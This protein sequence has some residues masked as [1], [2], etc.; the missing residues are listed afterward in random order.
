M[1][2]TINIHS[3]NSNVPGSCW[4]VSQFKFVLMSAFL[5]QFT[6]FVETQFGVGFKNKV[7]FTKAKFAKPSAAF[8][9]GWPFNYFPFDCMF[10]VLILQFPNIFRKAGFAWLSALFYRL[11][12]VGEAFF[13]S[14]FGCPN[15]ELLSLVGGDSCLVDDCRLEAVSWQGAFIRH[16]AIA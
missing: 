11:F 5:H 4:N 2:K 6:V 7:F 12:V 16:V 3:S 8:V 15:V 10:N 9:G 13:K 1:T 14:W